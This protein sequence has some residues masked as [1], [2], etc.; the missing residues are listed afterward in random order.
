MN[1]SIVEG[2]LARWLE[3][4]ASYDFEIRFCRGISHTNADSL[5]RRPCVDN[6]CKYCDRHE[7]KDGANA[8]GLIT[9]ANGQNVGSIIHKGESSE[10]DG[11]VR[12]VC[13]ERDELESSECGSDRSNGL[14][15]VHLEKH[16]S[17]TGNSDDSHK[18]GIRMNTFP[19]AL[20]QNSCT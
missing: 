13:T 5:S 17:E 1:F 18:R 6:N 7:G 8:T 11:F 19:Q 16:N 12:Q 9:R 2:Q 20:S 14:L 10:E 3:F 15:E 4:L